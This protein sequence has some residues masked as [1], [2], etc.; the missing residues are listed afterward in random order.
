MIELRIRRAVCLAAAALSLSAC[1][2]NRVAPVANTATVTYSPSD[3]DC[4]AR[5]MYF[6]SHRTGDQGMLAVGTVVMNRLA[7]GKYGSSVCDVVGQKNQ[8]A[9]GVMTRQMEG[10]AAETA[11]RNADAVLSGKRHAG[12]KTAMHF[13]TA[14]LRFRY[15]NM[16][17]VL[18]AGGNAFYEKRDGAAA[19]RDNAR[20][21]ALALAYARINPAGEAKEIQVASLD[22]PAARPEIAAAPAPVAQRSAPQEHALGYAREEASP[23]AAAVAA[24]RRAV[25]HEQPQRTPVERPA[26][27]AKRVIE[28]EKATPALASAIPTP[29]AAPAE[30]REEAVTA[31]P[32]ASANVAAAFAAF[33]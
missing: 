30:P 4:M 7:S 32:E 12:V 3:R 17:Y 6:E 22:A 5:A 27:V 11:R 9:P 18:V 15:P 29:A 19:H 24:T 1:A 33:Q 31:S 14:G 2:Q 10:A 25:A 26:Q 28:P 20:T 21:R 16:H 13:H 8:F 23:A